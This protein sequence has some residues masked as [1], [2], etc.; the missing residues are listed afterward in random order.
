MADTEQAANRPTP[1]ERA[2]TL[3]YGVADGVLVTPG[4]PY[5]PV[6]AHITG[7]DGVP[8]LLMPT[9]SPV[10]AALVGNEDL[11]ATLRISDVAPVAFPDRVR[12]R[13]WLHGWISQ[14]PEDE[15]RAA[16]IRLSRLHPRPELLDLGRPGH[17]DGAWTLLSLDIAQ[18]EI[19]DAWGGDTLEPEDYAAASPDPFV[20]IEA[21]VL[22]HLD[23]CHRDELRA[24]LPRLAGKDPD[25]RPLGL[26]RHGMWV[27]CAI[28]GGEPRTADL[29]IAF[30]EPVEDMAGLRA[31][32]RR[33]FTPAGK[34]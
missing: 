18:I 9:A 19:D 25:I 2:R 17:E 30:A 27:R 33:L 7:D 26:D 21:G 15:R 5:A 20:A 28:P 1:A 11:P 14:V 29:R 31:V 22:A 10:V 23:G 6:P 34:R 13:A 24:L 8:L 16:A 32:Y 4:V 12:G 3:A